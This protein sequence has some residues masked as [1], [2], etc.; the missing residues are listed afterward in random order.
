MS[1]RLEYVLLSDIA[2]IVNA[3]NPSPFSAGE[4]DWVLKV[5]TMDVVFYFN[6]MPGTPLVFNMLNRFA[7]L[8]S[9]IRLKFR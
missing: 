7:V 3:N 9:W 1:N 4:I 6:E 8:I 2:S 5:L